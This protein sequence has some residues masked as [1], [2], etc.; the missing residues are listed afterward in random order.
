MS[1]ENAMQT[2]QTSGEYITIRKDSLWKYSTFLL[3]AI[4]IVGAFVF[5]IGNKDTTA[6]TARV[7]DSGGQPTVAG[8]PSRVQADEDDDP[9]MGDKNAP[10]TMIEFGDY[11]CPFCG[12][13]W[14]QTLPQIKA[15][16]IDA[17]KLKFVYRDFPLTSIHPMAQP[18]AE[19]AEC[20]RD[21]AKGSDD[22]YFKYHDKIFEGQQA[23]SIENLKSW[24]NELGYNIDNCLNSGKFRSEVQKDLQDATSSGGQGTPYFLINGRPLSGAQPFAAFQQVIEAELNS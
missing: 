12:R 10:V 19:A 14:S 21:A 17:G 2:H 9:V 24:A 8:E 23:L 3:A 4:L 16:Y 18:A 11:Q 13:F 5:F 15:R 20:V 1:E 22:V 7:V 6:P